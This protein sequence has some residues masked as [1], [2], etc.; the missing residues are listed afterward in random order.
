[1]KSDKDNV[2][3]FSEITIPCSLSTESWQYRK[4]DVLYL[5]YIV[6]YIASNSP[7]T[8]TVC[9]FLGMVFIIL[10]FVF[11][12]TVTKW[13][14]CTQTGLRMNQHEGWT[15]DCIKC[16][17]TEYACIHQNFQMPCTL[18]SLCLSIGSFH[19]KSGKSSESIFLKILMPKVTSKAAYATPQNTG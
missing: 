7:M 17:L 14:Y 10:I 9:K 8:A 6:P 5:T 15:G 19:L 18:P 2:L 3:S 1:M 13:K 12:L 4:V 16:T 11:K